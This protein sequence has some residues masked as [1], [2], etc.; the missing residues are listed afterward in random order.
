M[1][2]LISNTE[3]LLA[4]KGAAE[5]E[6]L[7]RYTLRVE[8]FDPGI[9]VKQSSLNIDE[10]FGEYAFLSGPCDNADLFRARYS[11]S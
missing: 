9:K 8:L 10:N 3:G 7:F 5:G 2:T 11:K 1:N 4:A 6:G